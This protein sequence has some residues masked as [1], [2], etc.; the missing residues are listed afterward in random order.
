MLMFST[1]LT[2]GP[3]SSILAMTCSLASSVIL[4]PPEH[5][6]QQQSQAGRVGDVPRARMRCS[7]HLDH[8]NYTEDISSPLEVAQGDDPVGNDHLEPVRLRDL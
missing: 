8:L 6:C 3:I 2:A 4:E 1:T 7:G 5:R